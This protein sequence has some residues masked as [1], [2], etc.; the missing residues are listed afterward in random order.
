MT[1]TIHTTEGLQTRVEESLNSIR[2]YLHTDGGDIKIVSLSEDHV[3]TLEFVGN[4]SSCP[5][6]AMTFKAGVEDAIKRAVP[7]IKSIEVVN[8][9]PLS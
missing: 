7:E 3:L 6:S 8:V 5:M 1:E 4:C 9:A 2:P